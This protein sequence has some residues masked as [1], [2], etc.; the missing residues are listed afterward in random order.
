[1]TTLETLFGWV[2]TASLRASIIALVVLLFRQ[3]CSSQLTANWRYALWFPVLVVL[4][5]PAQ[6]VLPGWFNLPLDLLEIGQ[7][8][9]ALHKLSAGANRSP[10]AVRQNSFGHDA[11]SDELGNRES[12]VSLSAFG[13]ALESSSAVRLSAILSGIWGAGVLVF[14]TFVVVSYHLALRQIRLLAQHVDEHLLARIAAVA[15]AVRL[16]Q[17]PVVLNSA[18][19]QSPAVCG[20]SKPILLLNVQQLRQL[21][22]EEVDLVLAHELTHIRRGDLWLNSLLC[23]LLAVHWFNPFLWFVF[24]TV[25]NDREVVCDDDVLQGLDPSRRIVYGNALLKL[26]TDKTLRLSLPFVGMMLSRSRLKERIHMIAH[27]RK[28]G[29]LMNAML[30]LLVSLLT[31]LGIARADDSRQQPQ[32][33]AK[34]QDSAAQASTGASGDSDAADSGSGW[35][36]LAEFSGLRSRLTSQSETTTIGKPLRFRLEVKNFG[37]RVTGIDPQNYAPYRVLRADFA[38]ER[39]G[40]APFIGAKVQTAAAPITLKPG[41]SVVLWEQ[42]DL[43]DLFLLKDVDTYDVYAEGGEWAMQ[44]TWRDSNRIRVTLAPGKL[45]VEQ[46][47]LAELHPILPDGW[48]LSRSFGDIVFHYTPSNLKEDSIAMQLLFRDMAMVEQLEKQLTTEST[49]VLRMG[50]SPWGEAL[51]VIPNEATEHWTNGRESIARV[52]QKFVA[53]LP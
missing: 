33:E 26:E 17:L 13:G 15:A 45:Q 27:N 35:G 14:S 2:C 8:P 1:M 16:R 39:P 53:R 52:L 10:E 7:G 47:L 29:G 36:A 18:A 23:L 6:P 49:V 48:R 19:V 37:N 25:R 28:T 44:T 11:L 32:N 40:G 42:V 31:F 3:S 51:L 4:L 30:I 9:R 38:D 22:N 34:D 5:V 20:V 21:T 50:K 46:Q 41:E 43:N 24:F 12:N